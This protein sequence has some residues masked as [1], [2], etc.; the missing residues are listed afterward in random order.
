MPPGEALRMTET[1]RPI[2]AVIC[3]VHNEQEA[4]PLFFG[5]LQPVVAGL[6]ERYLVRLVFLNNASSDATIE[7]IDA[8][9]ARFPETYHISMSR[10]VGYQASL[11]R[12]LRMID[13]DV[14]VIIDV[15][16][17][18]PPE[19]IAQFL[20]EHERGFDI[21]Y[22]ERVDR[23]EPT[24]LKSARKLFY[25]LLQRFSD[26]DII[27]DM[28]EFSLFTAEVRDAIIEDRSTFPFIRASIGRVGFRRK[29]IAFTRQRRI[30][31]TT[32]YNLLRMTIFAVAGLLA[33]STLP[34]RLPIYLLPFWLLALLGLGAAAILDRSP[35]LGLAALLVFAGYVGTTI[36]FI[37]LYVAR[38]YKNGLNRP[39]AIP[40][41]RLS[42]PPPRRGLA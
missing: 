32:H 37:A 33:S 41:R 29:A 15:D 14:F 7:K 20:E 13:A 8:I 25:R 31:G 23:P 35:W 4:I 40:D 17:E 39:N 34:L 18:D 21:V 27:L 2:L 3:P 42:N 1:V 6:A 36:A 16:C 26:D 38:A 19:M 10:N 30:A 12:G 11:D 9:R 24:A 22:G 5:R 28:A